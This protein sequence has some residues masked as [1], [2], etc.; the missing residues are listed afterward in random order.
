M[1]LLFVQFVSVKCLLIISSK[2][3]FFFSSLQLYKY[4]SCL[5]YDNILL[6]KKNFLSV[7]MLKYSGCSFII[8][9]A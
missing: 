1:D 7:L 6:L 4:Y 5:V 8:T 2:L 3:W 9:F